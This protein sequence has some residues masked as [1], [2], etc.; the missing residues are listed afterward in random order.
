MGLS[1]VHYW[2][3]VALAEKIRTKAVSPVE[4]TQAL[5]DR[6]ARLDP[7][8][9]T[10]VTVTAEAAMT[11]ARTAE[12][13]V[14]AGNYRG[15]LHG[16]PLAVK[17]LCFT[18]DAPT[19][20]GMSI[21]R[22]W[23]APYEATV[24]DRLRRAGAVIL[25]KLKTAEGAVRDHHPSVVSPVNP[26]NKDYWPGG[27]TSGAGAS[28]VAGLTFGAIGTDTGGSIRAPA[29][30]CGVTGFKPTR[31]RVSRY[32]VFPLAESLDHV[33][34]LARTVAD[35][36]VILGVI[37]GKD[38]NDPTAVAN[39]VP[40]YGAGLNG[41]VRG[42][43]VG[44]DWRFT[45]DDVA[46]TIAQAFR[47]AVTTLADM[48]AQIQEIVFPSSNEVAR[49]G[50]A[51]IVAEA[52]IAHEATFPARAD[53]YGPGLRAMLEAG[54]GM[55]AAD[56]LRAQRIIAQFNRQ[57]E[58]IFEDVDVIVTPALAMGV[59]TITDVNRTTDIEST[60]KLLSRYTIP[61]NVSGLPALV[62][63]CGVAPANVPI[64]F[65]IVGPHLAEMVVLRAGHAFQQATDWHRRRPAL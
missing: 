41:G 24:V 29:S 49:A 64:N 6:I 4:V 10:Y 12:R 27:S 14:A 19:T 44:V 30:C 51:V 15:V 37:A 47:A 60:I 20:S 16:V 45:T 56:L 55:T 46:P 52:V 63:P 13:E 8:L 61:F 40:D 57:L 33:G 18:R 2:D 9:H 21:Y 39:P 11:A 28:L 54:R 26:W 34:P 50:A 31:G 65:Q 48:G 35:V 22:D 32:G 53:D 43:R 42:L 1:D 23:M 3:A 38:A 62:L 17:D 7:I 36:A 58:P 5:L 25:G 59:P